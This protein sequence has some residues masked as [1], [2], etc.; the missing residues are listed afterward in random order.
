MGRV[1]TKTVKKIITSGDRE[2]LLK[3]DTRLAHEQEDLG[4][5][6]YHPVE[7]TTEQDRW[8]LHTLDETYPK[9]TS[10]RNLAQAARGRA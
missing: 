6:R 5:S 4:G 7:K 9:G 1:R 2:V 8:I 3:D 10:P